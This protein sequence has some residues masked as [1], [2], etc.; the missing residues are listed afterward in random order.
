MTTLGDRLQALIDTIDQQPQV[1][2][3]LVAY[4]YVDGL[5]VAVRST[6]IGQKVRHVL[7]HVI[8]KLPRQD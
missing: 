2:Y 4:E 8:D 5:R 7:A 3:V 1:H 6:E